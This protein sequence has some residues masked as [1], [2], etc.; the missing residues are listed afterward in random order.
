ML[1]TSKFTR[2]FK[3]NASNRKKNIK[4]KFNEINALGQHTLM[5]ST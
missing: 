1:T 5:L 2:K 3:K 4:S